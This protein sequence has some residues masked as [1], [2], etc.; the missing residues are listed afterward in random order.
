MKK[1]MIIVIAVCITLMISACGKLQEKSI[2]LSDVKVTGKVFSSNNLV[3]AGSTAD[4]LKL[5]DGTYTMKVNGNKIDLE[6]EFE[7][8]KE[9]APNGSLHNHDWWM[10]YVA[11]LDKTGKPLTAIISNGF[12]L[13]EDE[14][15]KVNKL[16]KGKAGDRVKVN[17]VWGG[18]PATVGIGKQLETDGPKVMQ[19]I[20]KETEGLAVVDYHITGNPT[21]G[22][23]GAATDT[24]VTGDKDHQMNK[25]ATSDKSDRLKT[26]EQSPSGQSKKK[27][28][29][30]TTST[31]SSKEKQSS[32]GT[33]DGYYLYDGGE[34]DMRYEIHINGNSFSC[35]Y[36]VRTSFGLVDK[37]YCS[38]QITDDKLISGDY[39]VLGIMNKGSISVILPNGSRRTAKKQ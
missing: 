7:L 15:E 32:K 12:S 21:L 33:R 31:N 39:G 28:D 2:K 13:L 34:M 5:S 19:V 36:A 6:V 18:W 29:H 37:K 14:A 10:N 25:Q 24:K 3:Q 30:K 8:I 16:L 27:D 9:F 1:H 35:Q 4:Y 26:S 11:P 23:V 20:L 38:G 22:V 17:L